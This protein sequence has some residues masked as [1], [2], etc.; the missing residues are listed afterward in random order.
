MFCIGRAGQALGRLLPPG[1]EFIEAEKHNLP[2]RVRGNQCR[3]R[4]RK[5]LFDPR[6]E[7]LSGFIICN[8]VHVSPRPNYRPVFS[9]PIQTYIVPTE[10]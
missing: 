7:I 5:D 9:P 4:V 8:N 2:A 1:I 6:V 3:F 10:Y